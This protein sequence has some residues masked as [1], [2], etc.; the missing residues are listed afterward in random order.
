VDD[1][2]VVGEVAVHNLFQKLLLA[3]RCFF[4]SFFDVKLSYYLYEKIT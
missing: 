4:L 3:I 1:E 2:A